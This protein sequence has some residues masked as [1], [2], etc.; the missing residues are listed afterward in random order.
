MATMAPPLHAG[1]EEKQEQEDQLL[2]LFRNRAEL[3][4]E[5]NKLRSEILLL[6]DALQEQ[7]AKSLRTQQR[8]EQLETILGDSEQAMTV[9]TYY[10]LRSIWEYC[11]AKL[12]SLAREL[13]R[14]HNDHAH[15]QHIK[16]FRRKRDEVLHRIES[17]LK[18]VNAE[19][20]V[21]TSRIVVLD[22]ALKKRKGFWNYFLRRKVL[23][24]KES[25]EAERQVVRIRVGELTEKLN[26]GRGEQPP[27]FEGLEIEARR[28]INLSVIAYAQELFLHFADRELA[29]L[30][31]ES[32]IQRMKDASYGSQRDCRT[33]CKY[34]DDRM[35]VLLADGKFRDRVRYR[36]DKLSETVQYRHENE[37][38]PES[39]SVGLIALYKNNGKQKGELAVNVLGEEYWDIYAALIS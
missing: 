20:E 39:I 8:M 26:Q 22:A 32:S 27:E 23:S 33:L 37:S 6:Q 9:V 31:K 5:M 7:E 17:Q 12:D 25:Y 18:I 11:Q 4:K 34:A 29:M 36:A 19:A 28:K 13:A 1:D 2:K 3:K 16:G 14:A 10:R 35:R 21:L 15:R 24:D 38:V 30:I